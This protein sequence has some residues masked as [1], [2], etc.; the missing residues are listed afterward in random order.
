MDNKNVM[1]F[2]NIPIDVWKCLEG[3]CIIWLTKL[4]NEILKSNRKLEE[5]RRGTLILIY[6]NK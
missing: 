5:W 3:K 4:L 6:K 2:N 1:G